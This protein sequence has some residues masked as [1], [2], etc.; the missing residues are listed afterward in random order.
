MLR[1]HNPNNIKGILAARELFGNDYSSGGG[2]RHGFPSLDSG[3]GLPVRDSLSPVSPPSHPPLRISR[4]LSSLRCVPLSRSARTDAGADQHHHA[5]P[6]KWMFR[7]RHPGRI[8]RGHVHG[9]D[10]AGGPGHG[11]ALRA[12]SIRPIVNVIARKEGMSASE[13]DTLLNTQSGLL[14]I[15]GTHP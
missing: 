3:A 2:V 12:T 8:F 6:G 7:R 5:A 4:N 1:L 11:H 10:A 14:G 9:H 15:S 13:V